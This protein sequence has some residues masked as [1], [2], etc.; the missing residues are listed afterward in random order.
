MND[1]KY[2]IS[3]V[4]ELDMGNNITQVKHGVLLSDHEMTE[5]EFSKMNW[6]GNF[7]SVYFTSK[8]VS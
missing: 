2:K 8:E 5:D 1:Y 6:E 4:I 3:Y 7:L